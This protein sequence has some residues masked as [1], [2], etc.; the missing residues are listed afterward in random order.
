M[1]YKTKKIKN[2]AL[3]KIIRNKISKEMLQRIEYCGSFL[4]F[5][6]DITGRLKNWLRLIIVRIGFVLFVLIRKPERSS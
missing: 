4:E 1:D 5:H 2:Q 6:S 3:Q